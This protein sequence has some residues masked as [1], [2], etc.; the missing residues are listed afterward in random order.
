MTTSKGL[1]AIA[2]ERN[3]QLSGRYTPEHDAKY[4]GNQLVYAAEA[5]IFAA[6]GDQD[7]GGG[8]LALG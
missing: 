4:T 6:T 2:G 3:S 7:L 5:H 8:C 1:D